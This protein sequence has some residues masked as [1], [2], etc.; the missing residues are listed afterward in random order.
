VHARRVAV[1]LAS[2]FV[3]LLLT[4]LFA[5]WQ[6]AVQGTGR[7]MAYT[8]LER[9]QSVD[10]PVAGRVVRWFVQEGSVVREG[11]R[12]VEISDNDPLLM[13]RLDAERDAL[14]DRLASYDE[15]VIAARERLAAVREAQ[16]QAIRAAE[17]RF[18]MSQQELRVAEQNEQAADAALDAASANLARQ[19]ALSEQGLA[20]QRDLELAVLAER[21]ARTRRD[22]ARARQDSARVDVSGKQAEVERARADAT[23][24][25]AS[26]RASLQTS[27]ADSANAR[28][29]LT[30]MDVQI[31]RQQ[32]Q[33]VTAPRS[34]TILRLLVNQGGEQ[35]R[36]GEPVATLVPDTAERAVELWLDGNDA[37]LVE[38]GRSVRLQFEGW[39]AVQFTGWP[40]VAVGTFGGRVAFVDSTDDGQGNFRVVILPDPNDE[41]WPSTRFL[42]QGVRA[43]GWVLLR[44]VSVGFELWRQLNGFPPSLSSPP[45]QGYGS[46]SSGSSYGSS[47]S[48]S[49]YGSSS[50][51]RSG[52][53]SY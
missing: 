32:A 16:Q 43:N 24:N 10:S 3:A 30:R 44:R 33:L 5:P 35:V 31:A 47:S 18:R 28:A 14:A 22:A 34:G 48:G 20:S 53:G 1:G 52:S 29:T 19:R 15:Q 7:V 45:S 49:S 36:A 11:D 42:R 26:A 50:G 8:P 41:P 12:I 4:A 46:S 39:P 27:E 6:Q 23:S 38:P 40:S 9:Q 51:S 13:A 2:S 17:A 21:E 25:E 37:S